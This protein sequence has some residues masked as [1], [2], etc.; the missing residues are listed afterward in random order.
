MY[1]N[2]FSSHAAWKT[3][4]IVKKINIDNVSIN[5]QLIPKIKNKLKLLLCRSMYV[6][7][8]PHQYPYTRKK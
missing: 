5:F 4:I 3:R 7:A 1:K 2:I 8:G 6:I